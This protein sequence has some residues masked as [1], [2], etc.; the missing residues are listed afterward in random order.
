[1]KR[2][3]FSVIFLIINHVV[4]AQRVR[5]EFD[6]DDSVPIT[7]TPFFTLCVFW[8]AMILLAIAYGIIAIHKYITETPKEKQERLLRKKIRKEIKLKTVYVITDNVETFIYHG[9]YYDK[10][11]KVFEGETCTIVDVPNSAG[12]VCIQMDDTI[13]YKRRLSIPLQKLKPMKQKSL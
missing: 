5:P 12:F 9:T 7:I 6:L 1:M 10:P 2:I 11:V 3:Y 13:K 8:G 4:F